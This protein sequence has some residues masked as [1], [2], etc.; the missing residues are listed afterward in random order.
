M[1]ALPIR[2]GDPATGDVSVSTTL[3]GPPGGVTSVG[4]YRV[5]SELGRGGMANV[6]LAV[7]QSQ[8]VVSKL[9]VLKALLP[10]IATYPS[11]LIAILDV[12]RL[13]AQLYHGTV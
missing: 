5:L 1:T 11:A 3:L 8:N 2:S 13:A 9:V 10:E 12:A 4:K 6:Y 7:T